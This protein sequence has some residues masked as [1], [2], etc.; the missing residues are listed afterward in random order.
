MVILTDTG[1]LVA[2]LDQDDPNHQAGL[3]Q[4]SRSIPISIFIVSPTVE[5]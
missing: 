3:N 2:L 5:F 4:I 1:P